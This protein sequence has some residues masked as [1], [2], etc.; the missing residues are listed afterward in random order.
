ML[1]VDTKT[2]LPDDLL[3]KADKMSMAS[4]V[5]LRVPLL[6]VQV[7]EFAASLPSAFKIRGWNL[8]RVLR[9]A[10]SEAIPS[11]IV[12]RKKAGLPVPYDAWM[13]NEMR[14]LVHDVVLSK[15]AF[16]ADI[17]RRE[18][19]VELVRAQQ[20]GQGFSKEVFSLLVLELW[21]RAF[22][23]RPRTRRISDEAPQA[24]ST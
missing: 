6:D 23:A 24:V 7:L 1:Y 17:L 22:A 14:D 5:E 18:R 13:R 19:L 9:A 20:R 21:H 4:S 8:K 16:I 2:W 10:L 11:E 3:L 12:K 15:D